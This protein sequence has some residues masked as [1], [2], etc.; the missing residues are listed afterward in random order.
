MIDDI[1]NVDDEDD[2]DE[3]EAYVLSSR[4]CDAVLLEYW[5]WRDTRGVSNA[6][7]S[8]PR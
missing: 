8:L 7:L 2:D 5:S 1:G 3:V 4:V 6:T